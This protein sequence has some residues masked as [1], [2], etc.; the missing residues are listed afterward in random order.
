[1]QPIPASRALF[2]RCEPLTP[3]WTGDA[4]GQG[5]RTRETGLLGSLR[6]WYEA[7]L[8]GC[9]FP[10]CDPT[11]GTC[12]YEDRDGL[13]GIC[14]ACQLFGCTGYSRRFRLEVE[15]GGGVGQAS[16]IRLKNPG[17]PNHRGW[18]IPRSITNP[19]TL[20]VLPLYPKFVDTGGLLL[21]LALI[22]RFGALGAKASHGQG[23]VQFGDVP[24]GPALTEWITSLK[25]KAAKNAASSQSSAPSLLNLVGASIEIVPQKDWWRQ[26]PVQMGDLQGFG[27]SA[28]STW[29]PTAPLVRAML[30]GELRTQGMSAND[31]HRV[32]GTIQQW[33]DPRPE[34]KEGRRKDR[35]KGSD[36][37]VTHLYRD[38]VRDRWLMRIFAFVPNDTNAANQKIRSV[39]SDMGQLK[40]KIA[41]S[42]GLA[43]ENV[44]AI[45]PYPSS[46]ASLLGGPET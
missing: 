34:V 7:I 20:K 2:I 38:R 3:A 1:M 25:Q 29:V 39:L 40:S 31:R 36:V 30:R 16:P 44:P 21:T 9:G 24:T 43:Q 22:E 18:R 17:V 13:A 45:T 27:V 41:T 19:F 14:L 28:S 46:V 8:R 32:M 12:V 6:W 11:A 23:V 42:I 37:F 5:E 10:A 15:G 33:G 4:S 35:T 26:L